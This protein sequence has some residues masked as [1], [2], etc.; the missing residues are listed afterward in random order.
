MDSRTLFLYTEITQ[1]LLNEFN[2]NPQTVVDWLNAKNDALNFETPMDLV[3]TG[4]GMKVLKFVRATIL[5]G[6]PWTN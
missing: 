1:I 5:K 6:D 2:Q 3:L 4:Q